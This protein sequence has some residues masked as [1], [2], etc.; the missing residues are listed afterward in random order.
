SMASV[1]AI[2][3][4]NSRNLLLRAADICLKEGRPLIIV[5]RETPL[6]SIH[7]ENLL[8]L[9]RMGAAIIPASPGFYHKPKTI[10]DLVDF[11]VGR[12]LLR[13]GLKQ[14]LFNPWGKD[15]S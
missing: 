15:L 5:T 1:G 9:S 8:K 2:A 10:Q 3:S 14:D 6:N 7:L 11:I 4:G 13:L 12:I